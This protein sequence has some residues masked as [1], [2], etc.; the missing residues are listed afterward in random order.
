MHCLFVSSFVCFSFVCSFN[1]VCKTIATPTYSPESAPIHTVGLADEGLTFSHLGGLWFR[2]FR[3]Q[4]CTEVICICIYSVFIW[5]HIISTH[6]I[7][8]QGLVHQTV[9]LRI[10]SRW[11]SYRQQ[12]SPEPLPHCS[13]IKDVDLHV[14]YMYNEQQ[15]NSSNSRRKRVGGKIIIHNIT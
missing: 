8:H 11:R 10:C 7:A 1:Y 14:Q 2:H 9:V 6:L 5:L 12:M 15:N 13:S 3:W 4:T